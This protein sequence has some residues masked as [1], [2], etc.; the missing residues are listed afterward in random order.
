M[1]MID[2]YL[3]HGNHALVEHSGVVCCA[4]D[5]GVKLDTLEGWCELPRYESAR[6][7][8]MPPKGKAVVVTV[9]EDGWLRDWRPAPPDLDDDPPLEEL[10]DQPITI[11][12]LTAAHRA[13][14]PVPPSND[15][16]IARL[17]ALTQAVALS[18]GGAEPAAVC[19]I[20]AVFEAWILRGE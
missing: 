1:S 20:A 7:R 11:A 4:N 13:R 5:W 18:P 3:S 17:N 10:I 12:Q 16:Q 9:D 8:T 14:L 2:P 19:E 15:V 6:F